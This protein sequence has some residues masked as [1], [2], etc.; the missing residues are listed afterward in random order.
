MSHAAPRGGTGRPASGAEDGWAELARALAEKPR[1]LLPAEL[2]TV[3]EAHGL[4]GAAVLEAGDRRPRVRAVRTRRGRAWLPGT[5][6]DLDPAAAG[7][8]GP[9]PSYLAGTEFGRAWLIALQE[10]ASMPALLVLRESRRPFPNS[11]RQAALR[12]AGLLRLALPHDA[13]SFPGADLD[14]ASLLLEAGRRL[15]AAPDL[16]SATAALE[17]VLDRV[18]NW[19]GFGVAAEGLTDPILRCRRRL[20]GGR[21]EALAAALVGPGEA[22]VVSEY[23]WGRGMFAGRLLVLPAADTPV[24]AA[25]HRLLSGIAQQAGLCIERLVRTRRGEATRLDSIL[26]TLPSAVFLVD[27]GGRVVHVNASARRLLAAVAAPD[28][29]SSPTIGMERIGL[30]TLGGGV[31]PVEF[32]LRADQTIWKARRVEVDGPGGARLLVL[33]DVTAVWTRREQELQ[34]E[35]MAVLG[36]MMAGVAHELNNP[37]ATVIGYA[38][39]LLRGTTDPE[40]KL[41]LVADEAERCRRIVHNLLDVARARP[42]ERAAVGLNDVASAVADLFSDPLRADAIDLQLDLQEALPPVNGDRHHLQQLLTNLVTNAQQALRRR[43]GARR[44]RIA[45]RSRPDT[46]RLEVED[47]G[48]GV[49]QALRE[50]VFSPF[51]TTKGPGSGTGLGLSLSRRTAIEHG[52]DLRIEEGADG[53]AR[54]VVALPVQAGE[55]AAAPP[56]RRARPIPGQ[57]LLV[58]DDEPA[59]RELL[60]EALEAEGF[61]VVVA[62]GGARALEQLADSPFDA[63]ISDLRMPDMDGVELRRRAARLRPEVATRFIFASGDPE[64]PALLAGDLLPPAPRLAKPFSVDDLLLALATLPARPADRVVGQVVVVDSRPRDPA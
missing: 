20:A 13:P 1:V 23:H 56:A 62:D 60:R 5:V 9:A 2:A 51:F 54:F 59:F 40:R 63:V 37:L 48:P 27:G 38:Q 29:A 3:L 26:E 33:D 49:P 44:I 25:R 64:L 16:D 35:K 43:P 42:P 47:N 19:D 45:T 15:A 39:L 21:R 10:G 4:A 36:E 32:C 61:G 30:A 55:V 46:V 50:R 41:R 17:Q 28:P 58:V 22:G 53:G 24:P 31:E 6:V 14:E 18:V 34:S 11:S 8:S 12:L 52:G 57:R 7:D